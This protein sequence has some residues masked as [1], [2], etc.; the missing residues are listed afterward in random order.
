M[1]LALMIENAGVAP[2][3]SFTMFGLTSKRDTSNPLTIGMFGSGNKHAICVLLR[4]GIDPIIYCG[5]LRMEF[6]TKAIDFKGHEANRVCV[7]LSGKN[8]QG[9]QINRTEELSVVVGYGALDWGSVNMALR[10]FVSNALDAQFENENFSENTPRS[11]LI[12]GVRR[13]VDSV[14]VSIVDVSD[15]RAKAG[16]TRVYIPLDKDGIIET[17]HKNLG[18]W[19]L[20][21]AEPASVCDKILKKNNRNFKDTNKS[22][23]IYR[24]GV[25]VR[26]Y[27]QHG[28]TGESLYDYNFGS[29]LQIDESRN[30]DDYSVRIAASRNIRGAD[31]VTIAQYLR[32]LPQSTE[33]VFENHLTSNLRI[34]SWGD[35]KE[36]EAIKETWT[37][38]FKL[39]YGEGAVAVQKGTLAGLISERVR[40]KGL[41]PVVLPE[42]W[43]NA[44]QTNGGM[45][46]DKAMTN[47]EREGIT[48]LPATMKVIECVEK[49]YNLSVL[50]NLNCNK[51]I[52]KIGCFQKVMDAGSQTLGFWKRGTDEI[53]IHVDCADSL[54]EKVILEE[55][56]HYFT[57]ASDMSRDFQD[58]L[59]RFA[60]AAVGL[61]K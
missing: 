18:R 29:E 55:L 57:E 53:Y 13:A 28:Q 16:T 26:Q 42:A 49:Y 32:A 54:L 61:A 50:F 31:K 51:S 41:I 33:D 34:E 22:A 8:E 25:F 36:N 24:R 40:N 35:D 1:A 44:I 52:P 19:F 2:S 30:C 48:Y 21:F 23:C 47:E 11:E 37:E 39:A 5:N 7:K 60:I 56:C 10:E 6:F 3:E 4:M 45:T 38:A 12:K 20:H 43:Y 17:F 27:C 58:W 14:G 59:I 9:K 46:D 15:A